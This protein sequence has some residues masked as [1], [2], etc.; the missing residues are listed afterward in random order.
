M[1]VHSILVLAQEET[2]E[3]H[4]PNTWLPEAA[5]ILWGTLAFVIIAVLLWKLAAKP[6][7]KAMRSRTDRIANTID[8]AAKA[9][10]D[11]EAEATRI[12]RNLTDIDA[13]RAR[14]AA[15][16]AETAER[17]RVEGLARNDAEVMDLEARAASDLDTLKT[18]AASELQ[19]QVARWSAD[20][21]ERIVV[22][23]LDDAAIERLTEDYIAKV[24]RS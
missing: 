16:A 12:R 11:A 13:E 15:D 5:E 23:Q 2:T 14:I 7:G 9:K 10:T 3:F 24:G 22:S 18:R 1:I 6:I 17:M 20:A 8:S 4:A 19:E 21:T